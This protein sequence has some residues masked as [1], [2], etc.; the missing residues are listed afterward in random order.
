MALSLAALHNTRE[1][2]ST[3][4]QIL[5]EIGKV[6]KIVNFIN[7]LSFRTIQNST[8]AATRELLNKYI[9]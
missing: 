2:L 1:D 7:Y 8:D 5:Q 6:R 9:Q 4:I 3:R